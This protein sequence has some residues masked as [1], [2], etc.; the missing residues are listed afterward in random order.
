MLESVQ[1]VHLYPLLPMHGIL[2]EINMEALGNSI[3]KLTKYG[4]K[5]DI[6]FHHSY[7]TSKIPYK[8]FWKTFMDTV[9]KTMK[10]KQQL[11]T[12]EDSSDDDANSFNLIENKERKKWSFD[13]LWGLLLI[14]K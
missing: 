1:E 12:L 5:M 4:P 6:Y 3:K 8:N 14:I 2:A 13:W 11:F 7:Y 10:L 9:G